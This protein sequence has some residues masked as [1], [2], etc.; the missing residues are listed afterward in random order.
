MGL[1]ITAYSKLKHLGHHEVLSS[2]DDHPYNPETWER[3]HV[4]AFVHKAFPHALAGV[5]DV[6]PLAGHEEVFVSGGCY[7]LTP[8]TESYGFRA[9]SY[10]G[11]AA[12]RR[13]LAEGFNPY[14][15]S[16]D[17]SPSPEGPF[18]GLLWFADNEGTILT[19]ASRTLLA[20]FRNHEQAYRL[21]LLGTEREQYFIE[22][23]M[24]WM[25]A[26]ELAADGG[27]VEFH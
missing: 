21:R 6:K 10:G 20:E 8:E 24:N 1:D 7:E 19:E 4:E 14:R 22:K 12:W 11:Y 5:P 27:A 25:R 16:G 2:D 13:D 23:Y 3:L 17:G 15:E 26:F 9:G 18:Y